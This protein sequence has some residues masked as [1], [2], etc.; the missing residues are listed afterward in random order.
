MFRGT[1]TAVVLTSSRAQ[2]ERTAAVAP[3][4][5]GVVKYVNGHER[6]LSI[7]DRR[8]NSSRARIRTQTFV[9]KVDRTY[10]KSQTQTCPNYDAQR[11]PTEQATNIRF[12]PRTISCSGLLDKAEHGTSILV[13]SRRRYSTPRKLRHRVAVFGTELSAAESKFSVLE[14]SS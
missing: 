8:G 13:D 10:C 2:D 3:R 6:T 9:N 4:T 12:A 1:R 5:L 14:H 11:A 7:S